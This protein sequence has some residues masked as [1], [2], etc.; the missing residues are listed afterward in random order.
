MPKDFKN[1]LKVHALVE[2]K[3]YVS[4]SPQNVLE[5]FIRKAPNN[6]LKIDNILNF[7]IQVAK[8]QLIKPLTTATPKFEVRD[9]MFTIIFVVIKK[10]TRR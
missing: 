2:I 5:A 7:Q 6:L 9:N 8:I 1:N 10:L 3:P 4:A